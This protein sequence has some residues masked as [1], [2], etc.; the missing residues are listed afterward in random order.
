MIRSQE[1][2][3]TVGD[4]TSQSVCCESSTHLFDNASL[5]CE[6]IIGCDTFLLKVT[7]V[8]NWS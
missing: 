5:F 8:A 4:K 7:F 3:K 2:L 6:N 1:T